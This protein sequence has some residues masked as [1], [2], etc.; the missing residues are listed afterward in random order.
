MKK[1]LLHILLGAIVAFAAVPARALT[2]S[3]TPGS[4]HTRLGDTSITSLTVVGGL[5]A[6]DFD[7]ICS[8]LTELTELDLTDATISA[9]RGDAVL[10]GRTDY[11]SSTLPAYGLF[12]LK[13][14]TLKLPSTISAIDEGALGALQVEN[15][16]IPASVRVIGQGALSGCTSLKSLTIGPGV[17]TVGPDAF[18]RC[19]SLAAVKWQTTAAV[20]ARAFMGC[21][22]LAQVELATGVATIGERAFCGC[23][24]LE[25]IALPASLTTLGESSFERSGLRQ[26]ALAGCSGLRNI[27]P[28]TFA[29]CSLLTA[30]SLPE[31]VGSL[32]EGMFFDCELLSAI[33]VPESVTSLPAYLF[34]NDHQLTDSNLLHDGVATL[35]DYSLYGLTLMTDFNFPQALNHL[36]DGAMGYWERVSVLRGG[37]LTCVPTLGQDVWE[38]VDQPS[39]TLSVP[40][41]F[42][43]AFKSAEQWQEFNITN[44]NGVTTIPGTD[45][46]NPDVKAW[47]AGT[48]LHIRASA[49]I[50][51]ASLYNVAGRRF[52]TSAPGACEVVIDTASFGESL[53]VVSLL[54]EGHGTVTLKLVR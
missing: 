7:F 46:G 26:A 51:K 9:Y 16:E 43:D 45:A 24:S 44:I 41:E 27:G 42:C 11:A 2:I 23:A 40:D 49:P 21:T 48:A 35:G 32:A 5:D 12:G 54:V 30:V 50:A 6:S 36:G 38:G 34:T 19:T 22:A 39:V 18:S 29:H 10:T 28:W 31:G 52:V 53:Y 37:T 20:P 33:V 4:L 14:A 8:E 17:T 15:L 47:F 25:G 1:H 13:L 3:V